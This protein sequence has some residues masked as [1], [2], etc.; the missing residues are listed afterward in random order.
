MHTSM[1]PEVKWLIIADMCD[2]AYGDFIL[3][4]SPS[5]IHS[6]PDF[7]P[8]YLSWP[9]TDTIFDALAEMARLNWPYVLRSYP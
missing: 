9:G 3:K 5:Y 1:H 7:Y 6:R 8:T 4:H 2:Q